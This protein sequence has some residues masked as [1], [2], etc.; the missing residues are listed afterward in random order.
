MKNIYSFLFYKLYRFAKFQE[1]T[2]SPAIGFLALVSIFE[3]LHL[4]I[5]LF[6]IEDVF[7]YKLKFANE[8]EKIFGILFVM[9]GFSL[10]YFIFIKSKLIYRINDYYSS[11][12]RKIWRE[13]L[14]FVGYF[15]LISLIIVLQTIYNR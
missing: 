11:L 13:N 2:V 5:L 14:L 1:Q 8:I 9:I 4:L 12:D 6:F 3:L 7:G 15:I 10:N